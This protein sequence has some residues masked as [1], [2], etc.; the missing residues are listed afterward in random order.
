MKRIAILFAVIACMVSCTE[1]HM[2]RTLGGNM[3]IDL[4]KGEKLVEAT[5]K[6]DNLWYLTEPM[7]EDYVPKNKMFRENSSYDILHGT[8]TFVESK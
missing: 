7:E 1:Q 2:T 3:T 4:P 6:E 5:W 8:V